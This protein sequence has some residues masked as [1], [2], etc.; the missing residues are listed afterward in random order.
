MLE[1]KRKKIYPCLPLFPICLPWNDGIWCRDLSFLNVELNQLFP[2]PLSHSLR[3]SLV[4]LHFLPLKWYHL[5]IWDCWYFPQKSWFQLMSHPAW[6]FIWCTLHG[7]QIRVTIC[8]LD[9]LLPNIEPVCYS[10]SDS[11]CC[12][13]TCTQISQEAGKVV[14][15]F[16]LFKNFPK[17]IVIHTSKG[18]SIL[19]EAEIDMC[20][21]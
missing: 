3:G 2:P 18:F 21:L 20:F 7:S 9:V 15:V 5:H 6:N 4:H 16:H 17:F 10:M 13:L 11:N 1:P 12:F 14:W 19:S 8:S